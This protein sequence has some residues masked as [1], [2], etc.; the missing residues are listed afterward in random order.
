MNPRSH[1]L[2]FFLVSIIVALSLLG[3]ALLYAVLPA[4]AESFQVLI[5]QVGILLGA[6]RLIRLI[7][8]ELAGHWIHRSKSNLPLLLAVIV[9]SLVTISYALSRGFW[10]LLAG[11][12]VWGACWSVLRVEGYLAALSFSSKKNRGKIFAVYQAITRAVSGGGVFLGGFLADVIG[13]KLT[14]LL[15]GLASALGMGLVLKAP[16][17]REE[18]AAAMD[19]QH[20][21]VVQHLKKR[22]KAP[23]FDRTTVFLWICAM[24]IAMVDQILANLTGRIV[25]DRIAPELPFVLGAASLS[26]ML[27][28]YK[29]IASL[30]VGPAAG[31]L[32]DWIGR[33]RFLIFACACQAVAILGLSLTRHWLFIIILLL[34]QF[35][36]SIA[37]RLGVYTLAGDKAPADNR[38]IYMSRFGTSID[39]G[40]SLGPIV[41]Y[42]LYAG[43]G[44]SWVA[45][46]AL[47]LLSLVLTGLILVRNR[48]S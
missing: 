2:R 12:L 34:L 19:K 10:G 26:G 15:Y 45:A 20:S 3:D 44:F 41:G 33:R 5:W 31:A 9:G 13:I 30:L 27:L 40:T 22:G 23:T 25:V 18:P 11:R 32:C 36:F 38:A 21:G 42:S 1:R 35:T 43:L 16:H 46:S 39:L 28:G 17:P 7:T 24:A 29:A 4:R 48:D 47:T 37:A 6:N 14:F 8:N